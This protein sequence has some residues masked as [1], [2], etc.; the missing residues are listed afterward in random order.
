M[1]TFVNTRIENGVGEI[2]FFHPKS[3]SLPSELLNKLAVE[4]KKAGDNSDI[5]SI[6]ITSGGDKAFCAG[7]SF[8][9]LLLIKDEIQGKSFFS[10]FAQ[11]INAIKNAP[12]LVVTAL[13]GKV[14]GGGLGIVCVSD[15]VVASPKASSKLTEL[16]LGIGP[17]VIGPI[18]ER[19]LGLSHFI[20]MALS[21]NKWKS[22]DWCLDK[23]MYS[24]IAD[25]AKERAKEVAL[26]YAK[27]STEAMKEMKN[28]F[29]D[30]YPGI[31]REMELRAEQSGR[32]VLSESTV[33]I[34]KAFKSS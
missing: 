32:L 8:D 12:K 17:F 15:Y 11:V 29:W 2:E 5:K 34:L 13:Q 9:E 30:K 22:A 23:G 25:S 1:E 28:M 31:E 27:Y 20:N 10:G 16:S 6:L 7:A 4:I 33:K 26:C 21:P 14:V 3:N 24:E 19:K 18:L